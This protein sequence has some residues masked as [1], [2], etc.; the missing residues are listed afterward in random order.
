MRWKFALTAALV[1]CI[2]LPALA[3][4]LNEAMS[5]LSG[6]KDSGLVGEQP[7]GYLGVIQPGV[8]A[9]EIADLINQARRAEYQKVAQ[10]NGIGLGDVEAIAGQKALERTPGGQ[11]IQVNG[12]WVRK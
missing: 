8:R 1:A 7:N 6:A 11:Y 2:S 10:Q 4:S 3:M 12:K 5:S 9:Q